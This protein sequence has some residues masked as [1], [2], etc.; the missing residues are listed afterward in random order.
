MSS[1][2]NKTLHIKGNPCIEFFFVN[3]KFMQWYAIMFHVLCNYIHVCSVAKFYI[4]EISKQLLL[5]EWCPKIVVFSD[6]Q[7]FLWIIHYAKYAIVAWSGN[8]CK[9]GCT[10]A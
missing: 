8:H 10:Y 2:V 4:I 5:L 7:C 1:M 6:C 3:Y 9:V